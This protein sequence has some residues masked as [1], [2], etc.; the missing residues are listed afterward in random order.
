MKKI[1]SESLKFP[2]IFA[3]FKNRIR[4]RKLIEN[5]KKQNVASWVKVKTLWLFPIKRRFIRYQRTILPKGNVPSFWK[6][7]VLTYVHRRILRRYKMFANN[8]FPGGRRDN[9]R[10]QKA[11]DVIDS[12]VRSNLLDSPDNAVSTDTFVALEISLKAATTTNKLSMGFSN[13]GSHY[14]HKTSA[15]TPFSS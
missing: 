14:S 1:P 15:S 3:I 4:S 12:C 7:F 10:R 9:Q 8:R 11:F 6:L 5:N 2:F 13:K